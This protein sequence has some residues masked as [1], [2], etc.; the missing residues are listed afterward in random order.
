MPEPLELDTRKNI[1]E[2]VR[3]NPGLHFREIKRKTG[4]AIGSLQYHLGYLEKHS[5]LKSKKDGRFVR[6]YTLRNYS[7]EEK[8]DEFAILR[9]KAMKKIVLFLI[10]SKRATLPKVAANINLSLPT[11]SIYL[12]KLTIKGIVRRKR[13]RG[14][15]NFS[16]ID[17]RRLK[18]VLTEYKASFIDSLVDE[19][20]KI[21]DEF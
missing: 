15:I 11:T 14:K 10:H 19:F 7:E 1:Y 4:L 16:L 12:K 2:I 21:W 5:V 6:Y 8:P 3:E 13:W 20:V 17:D 9:N 18:E